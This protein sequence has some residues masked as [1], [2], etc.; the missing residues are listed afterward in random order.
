MFQ[1]GK[2]SEGIHKTVQT[3]SEAKNNFEMTTTPVLNSVYL[4]VC[5]YTVAIQI[6]VLD[7][8]S[9]SAGY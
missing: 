6:S 3:E 9:T 7:F 8:I 4:K 5:N 1:N 2:K